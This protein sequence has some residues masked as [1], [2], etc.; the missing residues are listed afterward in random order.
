MRS[1]AACGKHEG[2]YVP[3]NEDKQEEDDAPVPA[4]WSRL[5]DRRKRGARGKDGTRTSKESPLVLKERVESV[6]K[7]GKSKDHGKYQSSGK[8]RRQEGYQERFQA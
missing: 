5:R 7:D 2:G 1:E 8:E 4:C 6:D 3:I